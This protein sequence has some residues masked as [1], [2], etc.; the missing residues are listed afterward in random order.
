MGKENIIGIEAP[1][2][3]ET[4]VK[5]DDIEYMMFPRLPGVAEIGWTPSEMRSWDEY[6]YRLAKH[7]RFFKVMDIN[8]YPSKR[9]PWGE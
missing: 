2:W 4:I 3:T 6:K 1:M 8:Y 7:E 9:V 5:L